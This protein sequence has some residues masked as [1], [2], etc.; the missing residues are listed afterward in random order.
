MT[1]H[2]YHFVATKSHKDGTSTSIDGIATLRLPIES[3]DDY[4]QLKKLVIGEGVNQEGWIISSLAYL[5][6]DKP[7]SKKYTPN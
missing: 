4:R 3:M 7:T 1:K 5:G 6:N 2:I